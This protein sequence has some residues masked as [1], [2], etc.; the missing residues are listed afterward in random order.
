MCI[1]TAH[2]SCIF[3]GEIWVTGGRTAE[4]VT[5]NLLDSYKVADV[6]HSENGGNTEQSVHWPGQTNN[7]STVGLFIAIWKQ[8][9]ELTGDFFAQ[10]TD[11]TQPGPIAPWY[12]PPLFDAT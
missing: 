2:A 6:W 12:G 3:K 10:N 7:T 1:S 9:T 8:V 4:Y 11:V 5:W